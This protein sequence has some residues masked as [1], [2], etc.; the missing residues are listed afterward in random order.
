MRTRKTEFASSIA[1]GV[2]LFLPAFAYPQ[3]PFYQGRLRSYRGAMRGYGGPTD[4]GHDSLSA[5]IHSR[6]PERCERVYPG[7]R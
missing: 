5:E 2:L 4:K 7:R 3:A 6:K 1:F